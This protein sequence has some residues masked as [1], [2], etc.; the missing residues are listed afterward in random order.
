MKHLLIL[1]TVAILASG[2]M[3]SAYTWTASCNS[4]YSNPSN[5]TYIFDVKLGERGGCPSDKLK[6][7]YGSN[8]WDWYERAEVKTKSN[9]MFGK[10]K[11]SATIDIKRNCRPAYRNTLFQVHAGGNLVN[12]PSWFGINSYNKFKTNAEGGGDTRHAVPIGSFK[13]TA[14]I[15]ATRKKVKVD[16]F[17]NDQLV[18][19]TLEYSL[20]NEYDKLYF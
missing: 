8:G 14:K 20:G 1:S 17:V 9:D 18:T 6:Q 13:L 2:C 5:S 15:N 12:P 19:S 16:Y 4:N 11:W 10:W 3:A 7:E